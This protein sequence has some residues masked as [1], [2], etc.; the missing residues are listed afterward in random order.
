MECCRAARQRRRAAHAESLRELTLE[1]VDVRAE[2][3]DPV[4][5]ER[6]EQQGALGVT[7]IGRRQ[8]QA[9]HRTTVPFSA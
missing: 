4:G 6:V 5:V 8:E 7:D 2:W 3:R 1:R 9:A